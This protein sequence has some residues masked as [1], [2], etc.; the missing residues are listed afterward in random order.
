MIQIYI[1]LY[2]YKTE[3]LCFTAEINITLYIT[4]TS[5]FFSYTSILKNEE[6]KKTR[7]SPV[8]EWLRLRTP[9][10]GGPGSIPGMGLDPTYHKEDQRSRVLQLRPSTAKI[11]NFLMKKINITMKKKIKT[12]ISYLNLNFIFE[13]RLKV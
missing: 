7:T 1:Y 12:G 13:R 3:S 11:N 9:N 4:Y 8:V 5:I 10:A 2:M 6:K